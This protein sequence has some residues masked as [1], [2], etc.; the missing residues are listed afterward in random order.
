MADALK[1]AQ[2]LIEN[3]ALLEADCVLRHLAAEVRALRHIR[4]VARELVASEAYDGEPSEEQDR[5]AYQRWI[6]ARKRLYAALEGLG[7]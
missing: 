3:H 6:G 2:E 1:D 4:D 7:R 5:A